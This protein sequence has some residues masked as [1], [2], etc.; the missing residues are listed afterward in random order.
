MIDPNLNILA[1][2]PQRHPFVMIDRLLYV[3]EKKGRSQL[4]IRASNILVED[5]VLSSSGLVENIAQT[6]AADMG[7][8][9]LQEERP[10]PIEYICSGQN[11]DI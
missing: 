6:A 4:T 5:E 1:L 2:I 9:C 11:L 3:D 10:V 8:I 7:Y